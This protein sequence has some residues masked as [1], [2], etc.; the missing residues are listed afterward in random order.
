M[1]VSNTGI[2]FQVLHALESQNI[3]IRFSKVAQNFTAVCLLI[4]VHL[5]SPG[6][7]AYFHLYGFLSVCSFPFLLWDLESLKF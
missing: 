6:C 2:C 1:P 4:K 5:R 7:L 3:E